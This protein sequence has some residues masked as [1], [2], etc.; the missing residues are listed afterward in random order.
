M[1]FSATG[2][3]FDEGVQNVIDVPARLPGLEPEG[4]YTHFA[5]SDEEG[6]ENEQYTREQFSLFCRVGGSTL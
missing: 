2:E 3:Y 1:A 5:V 6:E 4:V